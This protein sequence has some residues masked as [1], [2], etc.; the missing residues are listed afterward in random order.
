MVI[1]LEDI[2][3]V[4]IPHF[5][6]YLLQSGKVIDYQLWVMCINLIANK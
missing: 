3:N 5:Y 6:K 2:I 4:I 1:K